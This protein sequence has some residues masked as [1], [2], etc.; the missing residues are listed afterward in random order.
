[1]Q[2]TD[3][4]CFE[5]NAHC[6]SLPFCSP[7][8][9]QFSQLAYNRLPDALRIPV[10]AGNPSVLITAFASHSQLAKALNTTA[11]NRITGSHTFSPE[12]C[13]SPWSTLSGW[14]NLWCLMKSSWSWVSHLAQ[15][16]GTKRSLPHD[17]YGRWSSTFCEDRLRRPPAPS[18]LDVTSLRHIQKAKSLRHNLNDLLPIS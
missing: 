3:T 8:Q 7:G 10:V 15:S 11:F 6:L 13:T 16:T 5:D 12:T 14:L 2:E 4:A 9:S 17:E 1:M 18:S